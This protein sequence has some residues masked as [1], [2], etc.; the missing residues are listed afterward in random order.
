MRK[1]TKLYG[2]LIPKRK[3][4]A[5]LIFVPITMSNKPTVKK[6]LR[7]TPAKIEHWNK[8]ING[9]LATLK[10]KDSWLH[11]TPLKYIKKFRTRIVL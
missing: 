6:T 9:K 7:F 11:V 3:H 10:E 1:E 8:A 4:K 2:D 5:S